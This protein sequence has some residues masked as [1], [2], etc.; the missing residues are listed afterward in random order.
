MR[1]LEFRSSKG[2][3]PKLEYFLILPC[4][5]EICILRLTFIGDFYPL[6]LIEKARHVLTDLD[7]LPKL[8]SIFSAIVY[9]DVNNLSLQFGLVI[10]HLCLSGDQGDYEKHQK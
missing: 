4:L 6:L 7:E 5:I 8:L 3:T 2:I 1:F 10:L 9:L